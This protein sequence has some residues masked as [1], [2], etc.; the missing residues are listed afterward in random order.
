MDV[1]FQQVRKLGE[2]FLGAD[3]SMTYFSDDRGPAIYAG[4]S[5]WLGFALDLRG[6]S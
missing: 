4:G 3:A 6:G 2:W 1:P 5:V